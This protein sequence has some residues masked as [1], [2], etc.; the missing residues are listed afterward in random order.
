MTV[1]VTIALRT[2]LCTV[3]KAKYTGCHFEQIA[4]ARAHDNA[5]DSKR[6]AALAT[7]ETAA[8][9][10]HAVLTGLRLP[11]PA[12]AHSERRALFRSA[13]KHAKHAT[14]AEDAT[15]TPRHGSAMGMGRRL[16]VRWC[17]RGQTL[18]AE[19]RL[20]RAILKQ[21]CRRRRGALHTVQTGA[22]RRRKSRDG[23]EERERERIDFMKSKGPL[24]TTSE[25]EY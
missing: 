15:K 3:T 23:R 7:R 9:T 17:C 22:G 6:R 13:I 8:A 18:K 21:H 10:I 5:R 24:V 2:S 1:Y 19:A 16:R 4:A 20:G 11:L 12:P 14:A 25:K